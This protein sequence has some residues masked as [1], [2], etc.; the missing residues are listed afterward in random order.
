MSVICRWSRPTPPVL[1]N[2]ISIAA[3]DAML[4]IS[5]GEY[6]EN[7]DRRKSS[8]HAWIKTWQQMSEL[9][10]D[11]PEAL[12]NTLVVAQRCGVGAP[13]RKPILPSLAGNR[14]AEEQQLRDDAREGLIARLEHAGIKGRS[15]TQTIF[16]PTGIR[17]RCYLLDGL[18]GLLP[19]RCRFHQ[20]GQ[21]A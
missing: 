7:D 12:A 21:I 5:D 20:M 2:P 19:D 14:E 16:R 13:K 10:A 3:H 4:C 15:R 9:F 6:V 18:F 8:P 17:M 1:P 11:V